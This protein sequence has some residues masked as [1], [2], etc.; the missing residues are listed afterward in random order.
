MLHSV[1]S[2]D[3][4]RPPT[5]AAREFADAIIQRQ[6]VGHKCPQCARI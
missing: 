5:L 2:L 4:E 3:Y 6:I 1:V